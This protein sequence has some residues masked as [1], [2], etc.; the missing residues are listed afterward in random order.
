[1]SAEFI[2][3]SDTSPIFYL[4]EINQVDLLPQ[5]YSHIFIP[6]A[7]YDELVVRA[8]GL[9]VTSQVRNAAWLEQRVVQNQSLVDALKQ[10]LD[11]GES[12]A[13]ALAKEINANLL[14]VDERKGRVI[15][16]REGLEIIGV[17]GVLIQAKQR[18]LISHVKPLLDD[19]NRTSFRAS[20]QLYEHVLK[21]AN[22]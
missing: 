1:M 13:I 4:S 14:L 19:L 16:T 3:V 2:V 8:K 17:L 7:V 5:L 18:G 9:K 21:Q 10:E 12:E 15:A 6:K 22:E 20:Q 11:T